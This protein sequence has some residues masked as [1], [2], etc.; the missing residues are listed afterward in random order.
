[1]PFSL[2]NHVALVTGSSTGL[3]KAVSR[4]LGLAGAKIVLNYFNIQPRAERTLAEF[5]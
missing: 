1:M 3:G 4:S 2:S 5:R